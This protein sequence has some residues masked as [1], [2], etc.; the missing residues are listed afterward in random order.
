M[1]ES[2]HKNRGGMTL[3][4]I[5]ITVSIIGLLAAFIIPAYNLALRSRQNAMVASKLRQAASAFS[6]Y[7][8]EVGV[9]PAAAGY[10]LIPPAMTDY[11]NELKITSWWTNTAEVGGG[12]MWAGGGT[13]TYI[14]LLPTASNEQLRDLDKLVDDGNLATGKFRQSAPFCR[15]YLQGD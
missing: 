11:F 5:L 3:V 13:N 14:T 9:F 6:M 15:Y 4:E 12:W 2:V 7:R 10:R 1:T 8:M